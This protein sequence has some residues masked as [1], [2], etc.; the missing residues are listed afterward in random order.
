MTDEQLWRAFQE[1]TLTDKEWNHRAHLRVA[2]MYLERYPSLDE[3][4][5]RMRIGIIRLNTVHGLEETP[6][7]GYH[8]TLTRVW[9][10]LVLE[11]RAIDR[12]TDS[13]AFI[14]R[15]LLDKDTPLRLYSRERLM[16]L[17]ARSVFV[18][19]DLP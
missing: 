16:S 19:P 10:M 4:H 6:Q 3:A 14:E 15:H 12:T 18:P 11:H 9:L 1:R 2:W 8:E 7:R 5:L 13:A 17:E